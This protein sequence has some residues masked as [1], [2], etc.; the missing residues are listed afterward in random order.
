MFVTRSGYIDKWHIMTAEIS[1]EMTV[2]L[3]NIFSDYFKL[4]EIIMSRTF[5]YCN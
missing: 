4:R 2:L 1:N 5:I 3:D